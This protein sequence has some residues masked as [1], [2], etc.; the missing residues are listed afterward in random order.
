MN[1][2]CKR[3]L[4]QDPGRSR[5]MPRELDS[6]IFMAEAQPLATTVYQEYLGVSVAVARRSLRKLRNHGLVNVFVTA[7]ENPSHFALTRR[8]AV[9]LAETI[10]R[11]IDEIQVIRGISKL[12]LRHHDGGAH[13]A[14][15]LYRAARQNEGVTIEDFLMESAIRRTRTLAASTQVPD[16]IAVLRD[17]NGNRLAWAIEIDLA[18]ESPGYVAT[19]KGKPY[20]ELQLQGAPLLTIPD[21]RVVC[22]VPTEQRMKRLVAALWEAGIPEGQWYFAVA[23]EVRA[24]TVFSSAWRTVRT[25]PSGEE[26]RLIG[27]AP[28][29]AKAVLTARYDDCRKEVA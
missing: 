21:W 23:A 15:A 1:K 25:S 13:L 4:R 10:D 9:L 6:L 14:A 22:V 7:Q 12:P 24:E 18:T 8:G 17:P 3:T 27:E 11:N 2:S 28:L 26:A 19:R 29:P 20:A 16:G 5:L